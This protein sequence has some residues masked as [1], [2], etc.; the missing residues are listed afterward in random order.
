MSTVLGTVA[1]IYEWQ[2]IHG[3]TDFN[4]SST[5]IFSLSS[6]INPISSSI[7]S[8]ILLT[9]VTMARYFIRIPWYYRWLTVPL[10]PCGTWLNSSAT[11]SAEPCRK[12]R[13]ATSTRSQICSWQGPISARAQPGATRW[14]HSPGLALHMRLFMGLRLLK[15]KTLHFRATNINDQLQTPMSVA[16]H[17]RATVWTM[18]Q[19]SMISRE[20]L[21]HKPS[22]ADDL[23][24]W[25]FQPTWV[26][27][28]GSQ[29]R[30]TPKS[31]FT[32]HV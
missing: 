16:V 25:D 26:K 1:I 31:L 17:Y 30:C 19:T 18:L 29:N 12:H 27:M 20:L 24:A 22:H 32:N 15:L 13:C 5:I 11:V 21:R 8:L 4:P 23:P 9:M 2:K 14:V 6:T 10:Y 3:T 7:S 28:G